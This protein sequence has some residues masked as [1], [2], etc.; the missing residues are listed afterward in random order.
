MSGWFVGGFKI[1]NSFG[2]SP[3]IGLVYRQPEGVHRA[4]LFLPPRPI[5][6][7]FD[8]FRRAAGA[9]GLVDDAGAVVFPSA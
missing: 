6:G 7:A 9:V 5:P 4:P 2:V 3:S 1:D 8:G